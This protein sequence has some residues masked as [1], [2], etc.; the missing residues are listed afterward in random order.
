MKQAFLLKTETEQ[1]EEHLES[2]EEV[3]FILQNFRTFCSRK[4]IFQDLKNE[5]VSEK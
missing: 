5:N 4:S 1:K 2:S 3:D